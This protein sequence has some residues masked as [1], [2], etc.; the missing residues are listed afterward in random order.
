MKLKWQE[1]KK[2]LGKGKS[3]SNLNLQ[4]ECFRYI[5]KGMEQEIKV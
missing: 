2:R 5:W 1:G 3:I 4:N